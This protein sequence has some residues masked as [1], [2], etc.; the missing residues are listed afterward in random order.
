MLSGVRILDLSRLLPGPVCTWHLAGLGAQVD[1]VES[2]GVGDLTRHIPPFV[3]APGGAVGAFFAAVSR[4]K[5]SLAMDLRRP[6][7]IA[8]LKSLIRHYDVVVEGFKPGTLE[9][10]G[11]DP[12]ALV[13]AHPRLIVARLSGYGQTGPWRSRPGHDVNYVGITGIL[14]AGAPVDG[15]FAPLPMQLADFAG[16]HVAALG[17]VAALFARE[18]TG[19]GRVLD[20]S[21]AEA[22]LS[23]AAVAVAGASLA[24]DPTPGGEVLTG[25][26]PFYGVY[27]CADGRY[28][29]VGAVEPKFQQALAEGVG[30][31]LSHPEL[32]AAFARWPR[33][34]WVERLGDACTGPSL[35]PSEVGDFPHFQDRGA[36]QRLAGATWVRPPFAADILGDPPRLG[37]HTDDILVEAGIAPAPLR[38]CGAVA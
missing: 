30:V 33:D 15:R 16:A 4:G 32:A 29:T 21:L 13:G 12:S 3:G 19:A 28:L 34:V 37:E 24:G 23:T 1:R 7:S 31:P 11:L 9:A 20:I 6:E 8:A 10:M 18:R 25:G 5:R 38:A 17:I 14:A 36:V 35:S 27:R 26:A 22:A 2:P